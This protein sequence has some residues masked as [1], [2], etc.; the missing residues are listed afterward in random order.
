MLKHIPLTMLILAIFLTACGGQATPT[1][2]PVDVQGTAVSAASTIMAATQMALPT[3]TLIPPPTDMPPP[4]PFPTFTPDLSTMPTLPPPLIQA[5]PTT[6]P[7]TNMGGECNQ[8]LAV[9]E[10]GPT[11][12]IQVQNR[13][14][15]EVILSLYLSRNTF[16]QCGYMPNI[17][18]LNGTQTFY[19]PTGNWSYFALIDYGNGKSGKDYG[20]F[21]VQPGGADAVKIIRR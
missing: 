7:L 21:V 19:L 3:A 6:V 10:A 14:G 17:P 20:G 12:P 9:S 4:T 11:Y 16:G 8:T 5:S 13:S 1:A 2:P 18:P 15:G